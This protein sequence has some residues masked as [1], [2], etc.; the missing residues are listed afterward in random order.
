MLIIARATSV[1]VE[2]MFST[3]GFVHSKWEKNGMRKTAKPLLK[4]KALNMSIIPSEW[5]ML[6][7]GC[8]ETRVQTS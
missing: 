4:F 7:L 1:E 3:F 5:I 2:I 8:E 6:I